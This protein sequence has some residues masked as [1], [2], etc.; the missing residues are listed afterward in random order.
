M[1]ILPFYCEAYVGVMPSMALPGHFFFLRLKE[2]PC[3]GCV[4]FVVANKTNAILKARKKA[5]GFKSK[6]VL[7]DAKRVHPW[8]V[9]STEM[10]VSHEGWLRAKLTDPRAM[11]VLERMT[12]DLKPGD[13]RTMS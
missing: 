11:Q 7:A 12:A 1:S 2:G 6:W 5:E 9:L 3:S 13:S 4:G 10:P 8:L